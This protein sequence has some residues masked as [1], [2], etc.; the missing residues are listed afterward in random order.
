MA[1][2]DAG[3]GGNGGGI[4]FESFFAAI[5]GQESGGDYGAVNSRTGA[6]GKYQIMPANIGPW[7]RQYLG[8]SVSVDQFRSSPA[9]QEQLARAV[10]YDY[11]GKYGA[12]GAA[13]AWYSGSPK[14]QSNYTRFQPNEP[15]IGE[16]V[17]QVLGRAAGMTPEEAARLAA[18]PTTQD[19]THTTNTT[20]AT[21]QASP[22]ADIGPGQGKYKAGVSGELA[23]GAEAAV[24]PG[25]GAAT[26][27][28]AEGRDRQLVADSVDQPLDTADAGPAP[29]TTTSK[30]TS[31]V[32]TGQAS[33]AAREQVL[34]YLK[35]ALGTPY[36]W[37]GQGPGGFD[38]SGLIYWAMQQAGLK[39]PPRLSQQQLS[40]GQK[41]DWSQLQVGDFVGYHGG[42][43]IAVYVGNNQILEAPHTGLNV[44]I[45]DLTDYDKQNGW[46]VDASSFYG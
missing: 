31:Q 38:C 7:S 17:D 40:A 28:G 19:V 39:A 36:V 1:K 33:T 2:Q 37:G 29:T 27:P 12:R 44:R 6:S 15:S 9:L 13:S 4:S 45:R 21:T 3:S 26:S 8:K 10:L 46:G 20:D 23:P 32:V 5:A 30:T 11:Y 25:S 35:Q 34:H 43:H 14:G 22:L 18:P 41:E 24:S 16:Y 42:S